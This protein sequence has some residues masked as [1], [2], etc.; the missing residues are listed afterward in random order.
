MPTCPNLLTKQSF[1]FL[2]NIFSTRIS[3]NS[4]M[5]CCY[6]T[7]KTVNIGVYLFQF[8]KCNNYETSLSNTIWYDVCAYTSWVGLEK[9]D[10]DERK[11]KLHH[12]PLPLI[13]LPLVFPLIPYTWFFWGKLAIFQIRGFQRLL[14]MRITSKNVKMKILIWKDCSR[15]QVSAFLVV[16]RVC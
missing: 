5:S 1:I 11:D 15:T 8:N 6:N 14:Y 4:F 3:R 13:L 7:H 10:K 9:K 12:F 16:P 2:Q